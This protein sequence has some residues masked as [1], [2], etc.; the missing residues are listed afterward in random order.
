VY[1]APDELPQWEATALAIIDSLDTIPPEATPAAEITLSQTYTSPDNSLSLSYPDDWQAV[2][3]PSTADLLN[4]NM[5]SSDKAL[6]KDIMFGLTSI[7][8]GEVALHWMVGSPSAL[9]GELID[10]E[11]TDEP[12]TFLQSYVDRFNQVFP[13]EVSE[14][15]AVSIHDLPAARLDYS[16]TKRGQGFVMVVRLES[17]RVAMIVLSTAAGEL[18]DWEST[19]QSIIDSL[20]YQAPG[21]AT[22]S[23]ALAL[24]QHF[25]SRDEL[26]TFDYPAD[27]MSDVSEYGTS[28]L[29]VSIASTGSALHKDSLTRSTD[30]FAPDQVRVSISTGKKADLIRT[31]GAKADAT[32]T[33][34]L[35][36]LLK[37]LAGSGDTQVA[38]I[39]AL[40]VGDYTAARAAFSVPQLADGTITLID[41]GNG[42][43]GLSVVYFAPG[44]AGRWDATIE[45][46]FDSMVY[47]T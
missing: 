14:A 27:W 26:L 36:G 29:D 3:G 7:Q 30:R 35:A 9:I 43:I 18:A 33:N 39:E 5:G 38:D 21:E 16:D 6:S 20:V 44:E 45:A 10:I 2:T 11:N 31:A 13:R 42:V 22:P 46:L 24:T 37:G 28:R 17:G 4:I 8:P 1:A 15:A 23:P 40:T 41:F 12:V 25:A 32:L 47:N 19:A 34:I